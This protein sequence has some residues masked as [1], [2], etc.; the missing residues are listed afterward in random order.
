MS[1]AIS[2]RNCSTVSN[3]RQQYWS[4]P[5]QQKLMSVRKYA[6]KTIF[7]PSKAPST[8]NV[9]P[10]ASCLVPAKTAAVSNGQILK[11]PVVKSAVPIYKDDNAK[12][13]HKLAAD[14]KHTQLFSTL[15]VLSAAT[16]CV[17][18]LAEAGEFAWESLNR[19]LFVRVTCITRYVSSR[20]AVAPNALHGAASIEQPVSCYCCCFPLILL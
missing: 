8:A 1:K 16:A 7:H 11:E 18:A 6:P 12:D 10:T 3:A 4:P 9:P 13:L 2:M 20:F 17:N 14:V 19:L 15:V 5:A